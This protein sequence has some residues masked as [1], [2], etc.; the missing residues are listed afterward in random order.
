MLIP[1]LLQGLPLLALKYIFSDV[2]KLNSGNVT[3]AT[4]AVNLQIEEKAGVG[5]R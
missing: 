1:G 2:I 4:L 5:V 3:K